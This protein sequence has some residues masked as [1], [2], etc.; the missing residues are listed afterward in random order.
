IAVVA[1]ADR[2]ILGRAAHDFTKEIMRRATENL[3]VS[4]GD[5]GNGPLGTVEG[6]ELRAFLMNLDEFALM[7]HKLERRLR[8]PR[9]VQ[10]L[11]NADLAVDGKPDFSDRANLEKLAAELK[12]A[13]VE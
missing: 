11:V 1:V 4:Y 9:V 8:E 2:Q 13:G 3:T 12:Q 10:A 7:F 6:G 5:N